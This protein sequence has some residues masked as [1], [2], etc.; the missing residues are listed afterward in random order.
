MVA[1]AVVYFAAQRFGGQ[2]RR[3]GLLTEKDA[4]VLSDFTNSTGEPVFDGTL[5][6]APLARSLF[7]FAVQL[8]H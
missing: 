1:V 8:E 4:L 2:A 3:R 6:Q 5:K 7:F